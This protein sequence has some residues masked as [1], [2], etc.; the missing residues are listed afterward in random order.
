MKEFVKKL[1]PNRRHLLN[2]QGV[3]RIS[4]LQKLEVRFGSCN[5]ESFCERGTEVC[6]QLREKC[7]CADYRK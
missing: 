3:R 5:V 2:E 4:G 1:T 7:I 6:E